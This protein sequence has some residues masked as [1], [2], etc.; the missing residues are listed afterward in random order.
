MG[1]WNETKSLTNS[2]TKELSENLSCIIASGLASSTTNKYSSAWK[3]WVDWCKENPGIKVVPATPFSV[4]LYLSYVLET[5]NNQGAIV[6]AFY[7][8][9][10]GHTIMGFP[11]PTTS[12]FVK[13]AFEGCQRLC[14][15]EKRGPKE[16]IPPE[17]L[18][19]FYDNLSKSNDL[20]DW[21][22]LNLCFMGFSGFLRIEELLALQIKHVQIKDRH[23]EIKIEKSQNATNI[24]TVKFCMF[25]NLILNI[26]Q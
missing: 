2:H 5:K 23:L 7:G 17:I 1:I 10:W 8:I 24:V 6:S 26:A 21:R 3:L 22:F 11:S 9:N 19:M 18:K 13:L 15:S 4:A 20:G 14:T 25:P 16:P 12:P